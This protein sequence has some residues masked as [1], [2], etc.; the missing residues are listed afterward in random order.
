M[1][2]DPAPSFLLIPRF[3]FFALDS[4]DEVVE[5]RMCEVSLIIVAMIARSR[6]IGGQEN[7]QSTW[8]AL[9][10]SK[11]EWPLDPAT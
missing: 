11:G 6:R 7:S 1:A 8:I 2:V 5:R 4:A 10:G 9:N 3:R